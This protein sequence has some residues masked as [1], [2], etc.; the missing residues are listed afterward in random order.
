MNPLNSLELDGSQKLAVLVLA[1]VKDT[2]SKPCG[3]EPSNHIN[4]KQSSCAE[5][6]QDSERYDADGI[7]AVSHLLQ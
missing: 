3:V 1:L 6:S 7:H 4:A 5:G 2:G